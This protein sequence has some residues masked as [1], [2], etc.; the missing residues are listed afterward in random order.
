MRLLRHIGRVLEHAD[1]EA[2]EDGFFAMQSVLDTHSS[3]I[4]G[5]ASPWPTL[6]RPV[7]VLDLDKNY[8]DCVICTHTFVASEEEGED[9]REEEKPVSLPCGH[10][11]GTRWLQA[12]FRFNGI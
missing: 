2:L 4:N 12:H 8:R 1:V 7:D 10:V 5:K 9:E 6:C 3:T 11:Y